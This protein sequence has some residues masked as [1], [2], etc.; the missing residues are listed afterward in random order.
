MNNYKTTNILL[1]T[2]LIG[3]A[4]FFG[5]VG[6]TTYQDSTKETIIIDDFFKDFE[7]LNKYAKDT[8]KP[9]VITYSQLKNFNEN[10]SYFDKKIDN[11][12]SVT[13]YTKV[14]EKKETN[15]YK[16]YNTTSRVTTYSML[17]NKKPVKKN[18]FDTS[19]RVT[20]YSKLQ[21][22]TSKKEKIKAPSSRVTTYSKLKKETPKINP[23]KIKKEVKPKIK[24]SVA[25]K[26]INQYKT[27]KKTILKPTYTKK[28]KK[29]KEIAIKTTPI[30]TRKKP[31]ITESKKVIVKTKK[32]IK[33]TIKKKEKPL[34]VKKQPKNIS[35]DKPS[36]KIVSKQK[37]ESYKPFTTTKKGTLVYAKKELTTAENINLIEKAPVYPSCKNT[38][39][40]D[41][42]K[43]CLLT[44]VS[45]FVLQHFN[46]KIGKN[47]GL[48]KGFHEI[49]VL[50]II[51]EHGKSKTYKV[52]GK[53]NTSVK[54]EIQRII[55]NLPTMTPGKANGKNVPVKYSVKVLFEIK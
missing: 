41:D 7:D 34:L 29:K 45:K 27:S 19:S 18:N 31:V 28:A 47:A 39:S 20:T 46:S 16:N 32:K 52:L 25:S 42:K 15:K 44:N 33:P 38:N 50:F 23:P 35:T 8:V 4:T 9:T 14:K 40:E 12:K 36:K 5:V 2:I 13:T 11:S 54:N 26:K 51:D 53:Y 1:I 22:N 21:K 48:K 10:E 24:K 6:F 55:N 3:F 37:K 43:A 49:R 30:T 17:K